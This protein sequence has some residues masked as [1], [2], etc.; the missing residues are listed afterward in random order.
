MNHGRSRQ[1]DM[2]EVFE[3]PRRQLLSLILVRN[4][5]NQSGLN[6]SC[7]HNLIRKG[8]GFNDEPS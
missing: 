6:Q 7:N 3:L 1:L 8:V 2:E 5:H 4:R